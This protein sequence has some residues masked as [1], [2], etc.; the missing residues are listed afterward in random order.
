MRTIALVA[1]PLLL[2]DLAEEASA[3]VYGHPRGP[4]YVVVAGLLCAAIFALVPRV[5]S[6]GL[7]VAGG[8]AAAGAL[9][10]LISALAWRGGVPNPIVA[11]GIAFNLADVFVLAGAVALVAGALLHALRNPTLLRKPI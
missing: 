8:I 1:A 3:P 7:A 6:R 2:L 4:G 9:G 10:N 5:A 11:G